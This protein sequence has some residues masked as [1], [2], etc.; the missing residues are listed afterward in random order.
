MLSGLIW[1]VAAMSNSKQDKQNYPRQADELIGSNQ[2]KQF[3]QGQEVDDDGQ[4]KHEK[5]K[6]HHQRPG[7]RSAGRFVGRGR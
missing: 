3:E 5:T 2:P 1:G 7:T 4:K 6:Y